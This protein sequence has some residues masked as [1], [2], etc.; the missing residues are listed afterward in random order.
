MSGAPPPEFSLVRL[1]GRVLP[2][3]LP[4]FCDSF[5]RVHGVHGGGPEDDFAILHGESHLAPGANPERVPHDLRDYDLPLGADPHMD[6]D[7]FTHSC[8]RDLTPL[9]LE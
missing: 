9:C 2:D 4:G 7:H 3:G 5:K 8:G 1:V 6:L